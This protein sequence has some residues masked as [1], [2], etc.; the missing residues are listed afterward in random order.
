MP[1]VHNQSGSADAMNPEEQ[2]IRKS[3]LDLYRERL[4]KVIGNY[5]NS[6][7]STKDF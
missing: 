2:A 7:K 5:E 3:I 6:N 4:I 1:A